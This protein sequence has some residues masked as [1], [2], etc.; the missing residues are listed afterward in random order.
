[1][2][3]KGFIIAILLL[4][5]ASLGSGLFHLLRDNGRSDRTVRALTLR[6]GLSVALFLLLMLGFAT[7]VISPHPAVPPQ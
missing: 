3:V 7:G 5:V 1:M 4:I 2:L 6:V